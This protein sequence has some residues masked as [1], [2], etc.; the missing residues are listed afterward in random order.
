MNEGQ[1]GNGHLSPREVSLL[2]T[3]SVRPTQLSQPEVL[4]SEGCFIVNK[5]C[6]ANLKQATCIISGTVSRGHP[7]HPFGIEIGWLA[8]LVC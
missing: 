7:F 5:L 4:G 2:S 3:L 1:L 6:Y 8:Y